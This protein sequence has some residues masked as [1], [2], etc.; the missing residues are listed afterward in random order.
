M[1]A[2][3]RLELGGLEAMTTAK[4]TG[5][6]VKLDVVLGRGGQCAHSSKCQAQPRQVLNG[7][8]YCLVHGAAGLRAVAG[9]PQERR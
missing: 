6:V 3:V 9:M 8:E 4:R 1:A 7:L 5:T 2:G